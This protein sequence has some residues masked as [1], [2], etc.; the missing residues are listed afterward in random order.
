MEDLQIEIPDE[1]ESSAAAKLRALM[2]KYPALDSLTRGAD[3]SRLNSPAKATKELNQLIEELTS[4]DVSSFEKPGYTARP[5]V[6]NIIETQVEKLKGILRKNFD[7]SEINDFELNFY[8]RVI[9]YNNL[10]GTFQK[11]SADFSARAIASGLVSKY[12]VSI[13]NPDG[14]A[15]KNI[16]FPA[17]TLGDSYRPAGGDSE[18]E[19]VLSAI[20]RLNEFFDGGGGALPSSIDPNAIDI[21]FINTADEFADIY[22]QLGGSESAKYAKTRILGSNSVRKAGGSLSPQDMLKNLQSRIIFNLALLRSAPAEFGTN[23][24]LETILHEYAHSLHRGIGLGFLSGRR[25]FANF[26]GA[27]FNA[28]YR[29]VRKEFVTN[30]GET[31]AAEHFSDSFS[32]YVATGEGSPAWIAFMKQIG[33]IKD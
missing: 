2:R 1:D 8:A 20:E 33:I 17:T 27:E 21:D 29:E 30:Y 4:R 5:A 24:F 32:K 26:S 9:V 16:K 6:L 18:Y 11:N 12:G 15:V 25:G 22:R 13:S 3:G 14:A 7:E 28:R 23:A 10:T 19:K 31:S